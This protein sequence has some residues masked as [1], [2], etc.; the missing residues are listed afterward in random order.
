MSLNYVESN[1]C[2]HT[3]EIMNAWAAK[4]ANKNL[5][6]KA[7]SAINNKI[8]KDTLQKSDNT[9]S[10]D[11]SDDGKISL[12]E[13]LQNFGKGI[14]AP[15]K[16]MVSSPKN[17]AITI[18]SVV[19]GGALIAATGGA[20][21]PVM[22]AAGLVGGSVQIGKGVYKQVKATTDD[23]AR[24][25]WQEMGSGTFTVGVSAATA[26]TALKTSG[27]DT[28]GMST[29]SA[30]VKC[31]KD[32]P[33]NLSTSLANLSS[34]IS[35]LLSGF[36]TATSKT[37]T[38]QP[39][40]ENTTG[41]SS[42]N[43]EPPKNTTGESSTNNEPPVNSTGESSTN[44]EPPKNTTGESSTN[45]EPPVNSTSESS[46]NNEPPVNPT[47]ESSTTN[48]TSKKIPHVEGEI[49][50]E[51]EIPTYYNET[52]NPTIIDVDYIELSEGTPVNNPEQNVTFE[53]TTPNE[54]ITQTSNTT[55]NESVTSTELAT[56][57]TKQQQNVEYADK[58]FQDYIKKTKIN[59]KIYEETQKM[60]QAAQKTETVEAPKISET[61]GTSGAS[62]TSG[63]SETSGTPKTPKTA[64]TSKKTSLKRSHKGKASNQTQ[65]FSENL[66]EK[67]KGFF[68]I[69]G[70]F[71]P[72]D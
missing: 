50:S 64:H 22:V 54:I 42:T 29:F 40:P 19:A 71:L 36:S 45:N 61:S 8:S 41:E 33:K 16:N 31:L 15:V 30:C 18:A 53:R 69:F 63:T 11:N 44:N 3:D 62:G 39:K 35:S 72:K 70:I 47:S 68:R 38:P 25:A 20:I 57:T 34:K 51:E 17:I 67:F 6:L 52:K 5:A 58:I 46:T 32:T 23:Q 59:S 65:S 10:I 66:T 55:A 4:R 26:K 24:Q 9:K 28:K 21:A 60:Y 14:V 2:N 1:L 43:N 48:E 56:T 37:E 49:V 7:D 27:V 13:K 12:K